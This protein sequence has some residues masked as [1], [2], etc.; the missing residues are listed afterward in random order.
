MTGRM[1]VIAP[2]Y[3]RFREYCKNCGLQWNR[4]LFVSSTDEKSI[5]KLMGL[6]IHRDQ[7]VILDPMYQALRELLEHRLNV[8]RHMRSIGYMARSAYSNTASVGR[9]D[10]QG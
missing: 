10:R 6:L 9:S 1:I 8:T 4:H 7:V 2:N 5:Y 3:P